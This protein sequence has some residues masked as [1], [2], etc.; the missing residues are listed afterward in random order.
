M[1]MSVST[2]PLLLCLGLALGL[3]TACSDP[4]T[5]GKPAAAS[6]APELVYY[7]YPEDMVQPIF[8]AFTKEFGVKIRY[9][10]YDS[11]EESEQN[12]RAGKIYDVS[13][14]ENQLIL[15]LSE[16][17]FL[18]EIDFENVPNFRNISANFRDLAIDP[19][20]RHSVPCSYG[21]TGFLVRTDLVGHTLKRF[22]DLWD[23]QYAGKIGLRQGPREIIGMTLSSLGYAFNSE[24]PHELDAARERLL[25]LKPAKVMVDIEASAAVPRLLSGE[26][27]ILHGYAED[28]QLAHEVNPAVA[29]VLPE[30]GTAL[31]GDSYVIPASSP[32]K[33]TAEIL[34]NFL[35]RPENVAKEVEEKGYAHPNDAAF[36]LINPAT[37]TDP[38]VYPAGKDLQNGHLILSLSPE[39][40][41]RYAE[42]WAQFLEDDPKGLP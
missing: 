35:L 3:L 14:I 42:I 29:Y 2:P 22:S 33:H 23:P 34:I 32:R 24:D 38:V 13:T 37:R 36:P 6:L 26:I 12:I 1:K 7:G 30:E 8:D 18:A 28:Y 9:L 39:G 21:T 25:Q 10:H 40:K 4:K 41:K 16:A 17:G 11:P 27:A 31:W 19:G 20:N 15:P 5:P